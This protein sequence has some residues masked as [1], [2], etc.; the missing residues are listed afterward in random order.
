MNKY[1]WVLVLAGAATILAFLGKSH[2]DVKAPALP[3]EGVV[4][5]EETVETMTAPVKVEAAKAE[6]AKAETTQT[7]AGKAEA[8]K[9]ETANPDVKEIKQEAPEANKAETPEA[10][11]FQKWQDDREPEPNRKE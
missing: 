2:G 10:E 9:A 3:P 5:I 1:T 4:V 11:Y 7:E 6:A 8:G